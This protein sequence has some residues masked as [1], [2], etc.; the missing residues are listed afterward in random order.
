MVCIFHLDPNYI[1]KLY[2]GS[3]NPEV[4]QK[5]L[6]IPHYHQLEE[7]NMKV[8]SRMYQAKV[9]EYNA[10]DIDALMNNEHKQAGTICWS[11]SEFK[12]SEHGKANAHVGLYELH[13]FPS[14]TQK[15]TWWKEIPETGPARPLAGLKVVDL[16]RIIAAPVV[17]RE[18]AELGASV[19]RV[20]APHI[21]DYTILQIDMGWGKWESQLDLRQASDRDALRD[22]ILEADVV[23]DGYRPGVMDK[24]GF[25]KNDILQLF[26]GKDRGI[27]YAHENCYVSC[28]V[29]ML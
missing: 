24:Y 6:G 22:L 9:A 2:P 16:A 20:T 5:A 25:G 13:R 28:L 15:P 29:K 17:T 4:S 10:A 11:T 18:L 19:M 26:E 12:E 8:A 1:A 3:L 14:A 23:L 21:T 7:N 27:I